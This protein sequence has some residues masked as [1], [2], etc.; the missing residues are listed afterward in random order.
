M[1][2]TRNDRSIIYIVLALSCMALWM[3]AVQFCFLRFWH[4]DKQYRFLH[5]NHYNANLVTKTDFSQLSDPNVRTIDLSNGSQFIKADRPEWEKEMTPYY[6]SIENSDY[7]IKVTTK[8]TAHVI[9][10]CFSTAFFSICLNLFIVVL[11]IT[12]LIKSGKGQHVAP[13]NH[14]QAP[15]S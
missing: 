12:H 4:Y 8:G 15:G 6:K 13:G 11:C 7:L 2:K 5:P 9:R 3:T 14:E 1:F 10:D